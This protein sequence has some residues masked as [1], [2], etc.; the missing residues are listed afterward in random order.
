MELPNQIKEIIK[1][2]AEKLFPIT[3]ETMFNGHKQDGFASGLTLGLEECI[4]FLD[5]VTKENF[6]KYEG[7]FWAR[8]NE[9][10]KFTPEELLFE[11]LK[12]KTLNGGKE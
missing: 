12:T 11:F 9:E 7:G 3:T 10:G 4:R 1:Q 6:H 5:F 2:E 8:D